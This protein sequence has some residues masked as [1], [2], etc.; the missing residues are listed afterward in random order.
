MT[1]TKGRSIRGRNPV[2]AL[3]AL[4]V[5]LV[6]SACAGSPGGDA[7]A[8]GGD[9]GEEMIDVTLTA[10]KAFV[11]F[12]IEVAIAEGFFEKNGLNVTTTYAVGAAPTNAL[13]AGSSDFSAPAI[14]HVVEMSTKGHDVK[15]IVQNQANTPFTIIV[16]NDVKTPNQD[17][18]YPKVMQDLKGLTLAVSSFGAGTD[19]TL[20]YLLKDAGLDP[21]TDV[22][23]VAIGGAPQQVAAMQNG[24]IDGTIAFD[25]IQGIAVDDLGIAKSILDLRSGE[26]PDL[27][28]EYAYNGVSALTSFIEDNPEVVK[29]MRD[30]IWEASDFI[31]D[32]ANRDRVVEIAVA[33]EGVDKESAESYLEQ[34]SGIFTPNV[35]RSALDNVNTFLVGAGKISQPVTYDDVIATD[36]MPDGL[37]FPG[38]K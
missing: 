26:G 10:Q 34:F 9:T 2:S 38:S 13:I 27:F 20:R 15:I 23:I 5:L 35:S 25:P 32:E 11:N 1:S 8:Q 37:P 17:A 16:L 4:S 30:A 3:L 19:N 36:Y 33:A 22:E 29:R 18:G 14:E 28:S 6:T 31:N 12:P 7:D 21:E 24:S